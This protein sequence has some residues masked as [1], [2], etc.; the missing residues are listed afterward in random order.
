MLNVRLM[1][2]LV[3]GNAGAS[4]FA[5]TSAKA[6]TPEPDGPVTIRIATFNIE[7]VRTTD[8]VNAD[9]TPRS[10][11][12]R[13]KRL[14][15]VIQRLAPNVLLLNELAYDMEGAPAFKPG[16]TPGQNAR[17][18]VEQ[19]LAVPQADGLA[20]LH[21]EV[22][23]A[24]SNTGIPSGF[25]LDNDGRI[26]TEYPDPPTATPDGEPGKQLPGGRSFG[27]DCHGFGT[28]PGQYAMALLVDPRLSI[29]HDDVRTFRLLPWDYMPA[30]NW[31][32]KE[33][34]T[35]FY[36]PDE[37]KNL[38]LSSK[39]HWDIPIRLPNSAV[40]HA[41]CSHPTPPAF[42]GPEARNKKRNHDEIR[43]WGEYIDQQSWIVDDRDRAGGLPRGSMFMVMGDLNA[44]PVDGNSWKNPVT[45]WLFSLPRVNR[46]YTPTST[47]DIPGLDASDTA[48]FK[49]RVDYV[50]PSI[51]LEV[52]DGGVWREV[53]A[54]G[55]SFPSDHFPVWLDV[56]VPPPSK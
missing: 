49:L 30:A 7:D 1:A 25:D 11:Q 29:Q 44:D 5:Q 40:L 34:G 15:E 17:R 32:F 14:A 48:M 8:L 35:P 31:P 27:N 46:T 23:T 43:F 20:P 19:Y 28:F 36:S 53:P 47:I 26:V 45:K 3:V 4:A 16:D 22:F 39:S 24:P 52:V 13:L 18:F 12:P 50:L 56:R 21:F 51:E 37:V 33:D 10:D 38:R 42:D 2:A 55:T 6:Q 9:G 54:G 41:L